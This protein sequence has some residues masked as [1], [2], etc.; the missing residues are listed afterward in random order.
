MYCQ[1]TD[2]RPTSLSADPL[3][4]CACVGSHKSDWGK[5]S[6]ILYSPA[7][8]WG[9]GGGGGCCEAS[10]TVGMYVWCFS[11]INGGLTVV[12]YTCEAG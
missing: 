1:Y 9:R 5:R 3:M 4:T 11:V 7:L 12:M 2:T 8:K 6:T 10:V